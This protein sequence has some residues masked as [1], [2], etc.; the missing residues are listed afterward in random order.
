PAVVGNP[1]AGQH[2]VDDLDIV[3]RPDVD[4]GAEMG[5]GREGAH[6]GTLAK[7]T[8]DAAL[9]GNLQGGRTVGV[10]HQ[11]IGTLV[12]QR[13]CRVGFLGRIVPARQHDNVDLDIGIDL[14]GS[15]GE[16]V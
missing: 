7:A 8:D 4:D 13:T 6:V 14:L 11:D 10:L 9:F 5:L 3:G 2:V 15:Q 12:D 16:G 1:S